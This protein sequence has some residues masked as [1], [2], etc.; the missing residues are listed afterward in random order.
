VAEIWDC[1]FFNDELD[2]LEARLR[3][4]GEHV[5]RFVIVEGDRTFVG[6]P[7]PLVYDQSRDRFAEWRDKIV[8][9]VARLDEH[10]A[11][12]WDRENQQRAALAAYL[13]AEAAPDDVIMLGDVDEF[14]DRDAF[15]Y[16][17]DHAGPPVRLRLHH[18][19]YFLNWILPN[20]WSNSTL[21]FRPTQ[22]RD[23]MVRL[24]LGD[25]HREWEGYRE[26]QLEDAGVHASFL[27]G[28]DAIRRKLTA[29]SH[30]EFNEPR[31]SGP[32]YLERCIEYGVHFQRREPVR[33]IPRE[34][35]NPLLRRLSERPTSEGYFDFRSPALPSFQTRAY[36]GYATLRTKTNLI[37]ERLYGLLDRH[38][39]AVTLGGAPLFWMVDA[40]IRVRKRLAPRHEWALA[41]HIPKGIVG[42]PIVERWR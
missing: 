34:R 13:E 39:G 4:L 31:I 21:V 33:I 37:P 10:A 29:Y 6:T 26:L 25:S 12:A 17:R 3:E 27:G 15:G 18:A 40:L 9:I 24:Q 38:P 20:P 14:P 2:L 36:C 22:F 1:F 23:P 5:D 35:M 8:H 32:G 19:V 42:L 41:G 16:L 30:Q 28:A 7:K 11:W